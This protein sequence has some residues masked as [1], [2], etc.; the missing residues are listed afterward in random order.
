MGGLRKG[1]ERETNQQNIS[2]ISPESKAEWH[3]LHIN[4]HGH[5][6]LHHRE[7]QA[8]LGWCR[9]VSTDSE[10]WATA[11]KSAW[12]VFLEFWAWE[13]AG[14]R[15]GPPSNTVAS[16]VDSGPDGVSESQTRD[17][18]IKVIHWWR[19]SPHE[20]VTWPGMWLRPSV[21]CAFEGPNLLTRRK[22]REL[23]WFEDLQDVVE[24][25]VCVCVCLPCYEWQL[26]T[27]L[28]SVGVEW[29]GGGVMPVNHTNKHA[30]RSR[31]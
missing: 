28:G 10:C 3:P 18:A 14:A 30:G 6:R 11:E 15:Q 2:K 31:R 20:Q 17:L 21:C 13:P 16:S 1:T 12:T 8:A 26:V 7:F 27:H 23:R 22:G 5:S 19:R 9:L 25:S 24:I 29:G 4:L